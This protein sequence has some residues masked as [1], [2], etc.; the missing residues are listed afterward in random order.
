MET[1]PQG[2]KDKQ[3]LEEELDAP[4]DSFWKIDR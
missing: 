4:K 2:T 3:N 1:N